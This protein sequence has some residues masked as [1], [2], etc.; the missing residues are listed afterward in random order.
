MQR[1]AAAPLEAEYDPS[2]VWV[3]L[4]PGRAGTIADDEHHFHC[5]LLR[6]GASIGD[7]IRYISKSERERARHISDSLL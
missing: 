6:F 3:S 7:V 1:L 4:V 5:K 2:G